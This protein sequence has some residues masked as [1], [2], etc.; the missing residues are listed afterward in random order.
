M[1]RRALL[2]VLAVVLE[3]C[4]GPLLDPGMPVAF[5]SVSAGGE[6]SCALT[7]QGDAYCWGRGLNGELGDGAVGNSVR[8]TRV[9]GGHTF[10]AV[11]AGLHHTCALTGEG[12]AFCWGWNAYGQL[13]TGTTVGLGDPGA[14]TGDLRFR[15]LSAGWYHTCGVTVDDDAYC[16]GLN[17]YG[18]LGDSTA[19]DRAVEPVRVAGGL[20][21]ATISGGAHHSCA[22]ATTGAAHCWGLNHMG[23]LGAGNIDNTRQPAPVASDLHFTAVAAGGSHTCGLAQGRTAY[24]W[25][26]NQF[27]ELGIG[28]T[29]FPSMPGSP[30]PVRVGGAGT[31]GRIDAGDHYTCGTL[32]GK[33][34]CWGRGLFGQLGIG[35]TMDWAMPQWVADGFVAVST[36]GRTHTCGLRT[37]GSVFCWGSGAL[38]QLGTSTTTFTPVPVRVAAG[39]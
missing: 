11:T 38:G 12:A 34:F 29:D 3:G 26:S 30:A 33:A 31:F 28:G 23:Q 7:D 24:C 8:L 39:R 13:G 37:D 36:G 5:T 9:A 20:R 21:L 14:V 35:T 19:L 18:Q 25:G 22:V 32:D 17:R 6:H 4:E 16:W 15:S 10:V 1:R 2:V 27:G